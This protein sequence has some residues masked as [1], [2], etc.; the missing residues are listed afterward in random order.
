MEAYHVQKRENEDFDV[1]MGCDDAAEVCELV[2][3][4][5]LQQLIQLFEHFWGG[6]YR[7]DG[8]AILK[9]WSETERKKIS[10][11]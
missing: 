4:Y 2:G 6:L 11:S 5:I 3:S 8:L 7:A 1:P 9:G 10:Q